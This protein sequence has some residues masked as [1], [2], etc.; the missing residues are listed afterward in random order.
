MSLDTKECPGKAIGSP[1]VS[2]IQLSALGPLREAIHRAQEALDHNGQVI[3]VCF[4]KDIADFLRPLESDRVHIH[5][6][7]ENLTFTISRL[8]AE[9]R[10]L[11]A[12]Q[13]KLERLY[14]K[15]EY[16]EVWGYASSISL[17]SIVAFN[18][19]T[20]RYT[21]Y[22]S[23]VYEGRNAKDGIFYQPTARWWRRLKA[24][25]LSALVGAEVEFVR[26]WSPV[27]VLSKKFVE[28]RALPAPNWEV[29]TPRCL[30][31]KRLLRPCSQQ[32]LLL[33]TNYSDYYRAGIN[34]RAKFDDFCGV[35]GRLLRETA[36][37]GGVAVKP[38]PTCS[39][40]PDD[41]GW[42]EQIAP[43]FPVE[44]IDFS[45]V[46]LIVGDASTS[47][48]SPLNLSQKPVISFAH[49]LTTSWASQVRTYLD[50]RVDMKGAIHRPKAWDDFQAL[51]A[52]ACGERLTTS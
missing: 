46:R 33:F 1:K 2:I 44:F 5:L 4:R 28:Q 12:F 16:A 14:G 34:D 29:T 11:H 21:V 13:R 22:Y 6:H 24:A 36:G 41:W 17:A 7:E 9:L 26:D 38:H 27:P 43:G 18:F 47:M 15:F 3:F 37:D 50:E 20:R 40:L 10:A 19:F 25:L 32:I 31:E 48:I 49:L 45:E 42:M 35:L 51:V 39:K 52:G 30:L 8:A 23:G